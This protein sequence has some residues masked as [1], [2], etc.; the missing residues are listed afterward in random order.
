MEMLR[1]VIVGF[2]RM[3]LTHYSILNSHPDVEFV[4]VCDSSSFM[5]KNVAS[6]ID[7]SIFNDYT[8]M[9]R[10]TS[11]D[12]SIIA[13]PT[14]LH[15]EAIQCAI[16]NQVHVFVEKPFSLSPEQGKGILDSLDGTKLVNQVG[17]VCRFSDV[18]MQVKKM[19][20]QR[21]LGDLI[22]FK[23]E[24]NGPTLLQ[25]AKNGWRSKKSEGGGCL[26]DFASHSIDLVNYMFGLPDK[27][28]GTVLQSIHSVGVEDA[29]SSTLIY[30]SGLR[31]NL[32]CNWSDASYRK[33]AYRFEVLG[34]KGKIIADL[35]ACK[36]F[37]REDPG[38][39]GYSKGW[40][41]NYITDFVQPVR[42]YV[43]G[44]EFTRQFDY[45]IDCVM[46]NQPTSICSFQDGYDT[47]LLI[48]RIRKNGEN[49]GV[50]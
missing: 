11:P 10:E 29:I 7:V 50:N 39:R 40:N 35:H 41:H 16:D 6:F 43:R 4:G 28:L 26:Y 32:L 27:V 1:G 9:I 2:G 36:V 38:I 21:V 8:E 3:G 34:R 19:L 12:F 17:Y 18:F 44:Y 49:G 46:K 22:L 37:F 48:D 5:L 31:G 45:F 42:F 33:P 47:D 23:M 30:K 13:V 24:M 15:A 25:D 20:D 14:V